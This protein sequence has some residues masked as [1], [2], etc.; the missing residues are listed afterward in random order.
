MSEGFRT[1]I[2]VAQSLT[3]D[4]GS[5]WLF[6]MVTGL[7]RCLRQSIVFGR[8]WFLIL[9]LCI[10]TVMSRK[11]VSCVDWLMVGLIVGQKLLKAW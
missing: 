6:R 4:E 8:R 5:F 3:A 2:A 9:V 11:F 7:C 10:C 1:N